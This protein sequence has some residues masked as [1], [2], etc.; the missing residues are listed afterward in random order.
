MLCIGVTLFYYF[1]SEISFKPSGPSSGLI[2]T[3]NHSIN[4][5]KY[6]ILSGYD[7]A[8][9]PNKGQDPSE[10]DNIIKLNPA[11]AK[12]YAF[13][14]QRHK[15]TLNT[16]RNVQ[17]KSGNGTLTDYK[18]I[19][20]GQ[21]WVRCNSQD[22][23]YPKKYVKSRFTAKI[24]PSCTSVPFKPNG[25]KIFFYYNSDHYAGNISVRAK[26][27]FLA[28]DP[29]QESRVDAVAA[30]L[31]LHFFGTNRGFGYCP[32]ARDSEVASGIDSDDDDEEISK[33]GKI[34]Y[35]LDFNNVTTLNLDHKTTKGDSWHSLIKQA[36]RYAKNNDDTEIMFVIGFK[37]TLMS[38]FI[39]DLD[40][41]STMG[42]D[43]KNPK[44][45]DMIGLQV[46]SSGITLVDQYYTYYPQLRIYDIIKLL[47]YQISWRFKPY[48]TTYHNL[49]EL[50]RELLMKKRLIS[51]IYL[52]T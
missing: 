6:P 27:D 1:D 43:L 17:V 23:Y 51:L 32:Q 48:F 9:F 12:D 13:L 5:L 4:T 3:S 38:A 28:E 46:D 7:S 8:V 36:K 34:D 35:K 52:H 22:V 24:I 47:L 26:F 19:V 18:Y 2:N 15:P 21:P 29:T 41:H 45:K 40:F 50:R 44:Y 16:I 49:K 20:N 14:Q 33:R 31:L 42:F 10:L 11:I 25:E 39:Y 30:T 37:G